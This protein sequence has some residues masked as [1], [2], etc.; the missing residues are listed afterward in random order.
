VCVC[1]CVCVCGG[2]SKS[3]KYGLCGC[4]HAWLFGAKLGCANYPRAHLVPFGCP[5]K[6]VSKLIGGG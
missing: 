4:F 6:T 1:V 3:T 2:G 5:C